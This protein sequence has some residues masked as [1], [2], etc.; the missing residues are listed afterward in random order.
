MIHD[1]HTIRDDHTIHDH[2]E[3]HYLT[4]D[5]LVKA[6]KFSVP[7]IEETNAEPTVLK[8]L[9]DRTLNEDESSKKFVYCFSRKGNFTDED[10]H[11]IISRMLYL[12]GEHP[13]SQQFADT[14]LECNKI[15]KETPVETAYTMSLC[16]N[17]NAPVVFSV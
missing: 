1:D 14:L 3:V 4:P 13:L 15:T 2:T 10:G 16:L 11:F 8:K 17:D 9:L 5:V 12:L 6:Q 7:C